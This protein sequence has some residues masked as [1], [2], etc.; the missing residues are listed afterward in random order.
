MLS[1][2]EL[3]IQ[4]NVTRYLSGQIS[5]ADF[6]DWFVPA[7]WDLDNEDKHTRE[8]AGR[9]HILISEFSSGDRTLDDLRT[10]LAETIRTARDVRVSV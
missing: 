7:L 2:L 10:G 9:L 5:L 1:D 3:G 8:L 4:Q 6:E